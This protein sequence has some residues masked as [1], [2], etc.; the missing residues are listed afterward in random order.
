MQTLEINGAGNGN[1]DQQHIMVSGLTTITL[2]NGKNTFQIAFSGEDSIEVQV[3]FVSKIAESAIVRMP[4]SDVVKITPE[5][6]H[7]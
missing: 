6:T 5:A 1:I 2:T 7:E 3:G 4:Y